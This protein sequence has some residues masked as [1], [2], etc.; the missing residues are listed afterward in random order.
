MVIMRGI[1]IWNDNT[2][3]PSPFSFS[4]ELYPLL[5]IL[6]SDVCGA[7]CSNERP[8]TQI[9]TTWG[10]LN[11]R[12]LKI[13]TLHIFI[14]LFFSVSKFAMFEPYTMLQ[15]MNLPTNHNSLCSI[16]IENYG[17]NS[18]VLSIAASQCLFWKQFG[19]Q[20][21]LGG[22][23]TS[24]LLINYSMRYSRTTTSSLKNTCCPKK[25]IDQNFFL[26]V[27]LCH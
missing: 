3:S 17:K 15:W 27:S 26:H 19:M 20:L 18:E 6:H 21:N 13:C 10:W 23:G 2:L 22:T 12:L 16:G 8:P 4:T 25:R 1:M 14:Q 5:N 11:E 7:A 24:Q 9:L